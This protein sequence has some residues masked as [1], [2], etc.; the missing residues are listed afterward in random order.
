[1]YG[2]I[3]TTIEN[4]KSFTTLKNHVK[5]NVSILLNEKASIPEVK[6]KIPKLKEVMTDDYWNTKDILAFEDTRKELRELMKYLTPT[7]TK[8]HIVDFEDEES[9]RTEGRHICMTSNDFDDYKAKVNEYIMTNKQ[10]PSIKKLLKNEPITRDDYNELE[11]IFT[12][13]LGT[14]QEYHQYY[15]NTPFGLLI[16]RIAKMDRDVAYGAFA[17]FIAEERP[18]AEQ[19]SFINK[20]VDYVVENGYIQNLVELTKAPFDRPKNFVALF[21]RAAQGKLV[22]IIKK[23]EE[24]TRV[25]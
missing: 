13:E 22:S 12:Q 3:L 18:N 20:V 19:I 23:F 7:E 21:S 16:R 11:R 1:M 9:F 25:A 6:D 24:N 10:N 4:K 8:I 14:E 5:K 2:L 17:E 15:E